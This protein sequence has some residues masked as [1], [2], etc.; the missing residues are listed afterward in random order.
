MSFAAPVSRDGFHYN[1]DLY[2]EVG[3]LNRHKRASITEI[4]A[5]LRPDLKKAASTPA[6]KDPV[7]HWYEAQL[8]HYGLPPSKD[9]A[10]AKMRLL[11]ALNASKLTVPKG[12]S[13]LE[14]NLKKE[15]AAADRKAKAEYKAQIGAPTS[16]GTTA[17]KK[18]PHSDIVNNVNFSINFG[19][20]GD[21]TV[22]GSAAEKPP[23]AKRAKASTSKTTAKKG[24]SE[25]QIAK[26]DR[27]IQTAR[28]STGGFSIGQ[29]SGR[30]SDSPIEPDT[31]R[32]KQTAPRIGTPIG[33]SSNTAIHSASPEQP[34]RKQ[35]ARRSAGFVPIGQRSSTGAN[36]PL[37]KE[38]NVK[39]EHKVKQEPSGEDLP[40]LGLLNGY[41]DI[42]CPTIAD[43]WP[44]WGADNMSLVLTLDSPGM[45]GAY[46]FG[47]FSGILNMQDRPWDS[48]H[49]PIPCRWRGQDNSE[50]EMSFGDQCTGAIAFLGGGRIQGWLSLYG[51]CEFYGTRRS[52]PGNAPR[53][54]ASMRQEWDGYNDE[55]YA[56]ASRRRWGGW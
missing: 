30:A 53:T 55:E 38:T 1:G 21:I 41:Y 22:N 54:A 24:Q 9:K 37:K 11:E 10:R 52:G 43:E 25:S 14:A 4:S 47:M 56:A 28:R 49:E 33:S 40:R 23:P 39:V 51:R 31:P 45:W 36:P 35:T 44:D 12:I 26:R 17:S 3:N 15:F 19:S 5:I 50:G 18:R 27:P 7:G 6:P 34:R 8:I 46:D 32:K 42:E 16:K 29:R 20:Q 13:N 2:V 48:S